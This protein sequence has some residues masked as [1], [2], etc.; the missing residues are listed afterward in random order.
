M[1][2]ISGLMIR[3]SGF[4]GQGT[5]VFLSTAVLGRLA[6]H[7][8]FWICVRCEGSEGEAGGGEARFR[9]RRAAQARHQHHGG[10]ALAVSADSSI[11]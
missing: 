2:P 8:A 5:G 7:G 9:A 3:T 1:R 6:G 11:V 10:V 4:P